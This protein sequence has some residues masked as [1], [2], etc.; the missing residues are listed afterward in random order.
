[1]LDFLEGPS[2]PWSNAKAST[3]SMEMVFVFLNKCAAL[4]EFELQRL[5]LMELLVCFVVLNHSKSDDYIGPDGNHQEN[6]YFVRLL[7]TQPK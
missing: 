5:S 7:L 4:V 3:F 2:E 1:M 6:P